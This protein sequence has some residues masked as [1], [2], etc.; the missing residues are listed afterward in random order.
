MAPSRDM[1]QQQITAFVY[2][3]NMFL[4]LVKSYKK[5]NFLGC[6]AYNLAIS[7]LFEEDTVNETMMEI[8][9]FIWEYSW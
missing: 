8:L 6:L 9:F 2:F 1:R 4:K 3:E 5:Q 7:S